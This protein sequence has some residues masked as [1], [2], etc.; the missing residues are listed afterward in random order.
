LDSSGTNS[1]L[2]VNRE[3]TADQKRLL[4]SLGL[5]KNR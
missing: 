5:A 4:S 3:L 2:Q 1:R